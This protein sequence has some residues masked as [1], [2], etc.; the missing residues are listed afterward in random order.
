MIALFFAVFTLASE[1]DAI[2]SRKTTPLDKLIC[3]DSNLREL[4]DQMTTFFR[5]AVR[6]SSPKAE[7]KL[8]EGQRD[9][10]A[11]RAN[12]LNEPGPAQKI[13]CARG[14]TFDRVRE[15]K[16][17]I[18]FQDE[19]EIVRRFCGEVTCVN[20]SH[21]AIKGGQSNQFYEIFELFDRR[22]TE[23]DGT[24][25]RNRLDEE[26][27]LTGI[28]MIK[29]GTRGLSCR[30][31]SKIPR[32]SGTGSVETKLTG[33]TLSIEHHGH[34]CGENFTEEIQLF[35]PRILR[36]VDLGGSDC[37]AKV[38]WDFAKASG[39][40]ESSS[41]PFLPVPLFDSNPF[42]TSG[43]WK[44]TEMGPCGTTLDGATGYLLA[45]KR[46]DAKAVR[47]KI[48][49]FGHNDFDHFENRDLQQNKLL[50]QIQGDLPDDRL[51]LSLRSAEGKMLKWNFR[52][53]ENK[54]A[55]VETA[56]FVGADGK[57]KWK[58]LLVDLSE[59]VSVAPRDIGGISL[60]YV[61]ADGKSM[62]Y[63]LSTGSVATSEDPKTLGH[64]INM[65]QARISCAPI[66]RR[67]QILTADS[68]LKL[69][70]ACL[71]LAD[72]DLAP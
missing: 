22:F 38:T 9:W 16:K 57:S 48:A 61:G 3:A 26:G 34:R 67:G 19:D 4:D 29:D 58:A 6:K 15:L 63:T 5:E 8:R 59:S 39:T 1:Q 25:F 42:L 33:K 71:P 47:A 31:I 17:V 30:R 45:G 14:E 44:T 18:N 28:W 70:A 24:A 65:K 54:D 53:T 52:I 62:K 46:E 50:I 69:P 23:E 64:L 21:L 37:P 2:C 43:A 11:R 40:T 12:C 32:T 66:E 51:E 35:P 13:S 41:I 68:A 49:F 7:K 20:A 55:K 72:E 60:N 36:L 27:D 56:S 10:L